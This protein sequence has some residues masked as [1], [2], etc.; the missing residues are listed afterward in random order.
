MNA[1][2]MSHASRPPSARIER[3]LVAA[4]SAAW[5]SG[6]LT[7]GQGGVIGGR[8]LM[9]LA[10]ESTRW[11]AQGRVVSLVSGTNGKTTTS[12]MLAAALRARHPTDTNASGA[13]T[14]P[15]L[16]TTLAT[17][18]ADHV[19]L[20]TDEGWLPWAVEQTRPSLVA[21]LN[22]SRDQLHRHPEVHLLA[23]SWRQ[24]LG[25]VPIVVANADDPSVVLAALAAKAQVWVGVGLRWDQDSVVCPRCKR[26]LT[27]TP[28]HWECSCG[29]ARPAPHWEVVGDHLHRVQH[30]D[31]RVRLRSV[32]PGEANLAN[33]AMAV[34]AAAVEGV[35]PEEAAAAIETIGEVSGRYA[36]F[37]RGAH[38]VRLLLAKNPAGWLEATRMVSD[39]DAP[40]VLGFNAEGV[41]GRD[42]SW[43]YDVSFDALAGRTLAVIGRRASDMTVRLEI[44]DLGPVRQYD[45]LDSA[46]RALPPGRVDLIANYTAF[47]EV[48]K[49]LRHGR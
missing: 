47:Q 24:A 34:A 39:S 16:T 1:N 17:G 10:P 12:A 23:E 13:N 21:L 9:R 35:P 18:A 46:L 25:E 45:S 44:D 43:L 2:T 37:V 42:P 48:W 31:Q 32:L 14:P 29:L 7:G 36:E 8:V 41:D 38:T 40:L 27:R 4:R 33:A 30:G 3:A 28:G 26:Q 5:L 49:V 22:L 11:F 19:V 20:E 15:G 6:R